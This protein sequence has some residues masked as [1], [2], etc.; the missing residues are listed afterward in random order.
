[1]LPG[2]RSDSTPP[3]PKDLLFRTARTGTNGVWVRRRKWTRRDTEAPQ[4][5]ETS[6]V[7][8]PN[9]Q[10]TEGRPGTVPLSKYSL[11]T[12]SVTLPLRLIVIIMIIKRR[13]RREK[14]REEGKWEKKPNCRRDLYRHSGTI[15]VED[16][17]SG[18]PRH[19]SGQGK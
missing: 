6:D 9:V 14:R 10:S 13:K 11:T 16:G 19:C 4:Q 8:G 7:K 3:F 5:L 1:M 2:I 12:T 18:D 17:L 15:K